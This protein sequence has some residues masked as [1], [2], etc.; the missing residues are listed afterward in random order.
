M[1]VLLLRLRASLR[2]FWFDIVAASISVVFPYILALRRESYKS[3]SVCGSS[4]WIITLQVSWWFSCSSS[5]LRCIAFHHG[6]QCARMWSK[7]NL[8]QTG[9]L[10]YSSWIK[11]HEFL[12]YFLK[13][14]CIS[15][16]RRKIIQ[17]IPGCRN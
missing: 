2:K 12:L 10:A 5:V 17:C 7:S 6:I 8:C 9:K 15:L 4:M 1:T 14:L 11:V 16:R 13:W 3:R